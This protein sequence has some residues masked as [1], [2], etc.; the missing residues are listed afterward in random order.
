MKDAVSWENHVTTNTVKIA[1]RDVQ[2]H[3]GDNHAIKDVNVDIE[4]KTTQ[5]MCVA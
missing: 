4:D 2:V 5:L 1:A 3:Y